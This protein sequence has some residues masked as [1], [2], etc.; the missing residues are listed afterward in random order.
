[1]HRRFIPIIGLAAVLAGAFFACNRIPTAPADRA[2]VPAAAVQAPGTGAFEVVKMGRYGG[3]MG[4]TYFAHTLHADLPGL[5]GGTIPCT[6]CHLEVCGPPRRCGEC[7]MGRR[8]EGP[9]GKLHTT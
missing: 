7:H 1:M 2:E 3:R 4:P 6:W 8:R 9:G 5:E